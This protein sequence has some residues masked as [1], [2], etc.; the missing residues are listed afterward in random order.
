M[1]GTRFL[2]VKEKVSNK[3]TDNQDRNVRMKPV[4]LDWIKQISVD[5]CL[6]DY[7]YSYTDTG[8]NINPHVYQDSIYTYISQICLLRGLKRNT[9]Q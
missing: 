5:S 4:V 6:F 3:F 8:I 7:M 1:I 2:I 9:T